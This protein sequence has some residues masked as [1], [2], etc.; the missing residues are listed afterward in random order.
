[1]TTLIAISQATLLKALAQILG[2][3]P[4]SPNAEIPFDWILDEVTGLDGS[5]VDYLL[6]EPAQ[7]PKCLSDVAEKTLIAW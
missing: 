3:E 5:E 2:C 1:M 6:I 7:C 4:C